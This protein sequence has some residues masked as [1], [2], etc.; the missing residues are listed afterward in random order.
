VL[1]TAEF[2]LGTSGRVGSYLDV[3]ITTTSLI[4]PLMALEWLIRTF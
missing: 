2:E 3:G 4:F 1:A